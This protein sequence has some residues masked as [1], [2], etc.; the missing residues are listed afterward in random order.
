M[1]TA[2]TPPP[3]AGPVPQPPRRRWLA[4]AV[5]LVLLAAGGG[6]AYHYGVP[7]LPRDVPPPAPPEP[8][9]PAEAVRVRPDHV[10]AV[11]PDTP[12]AR[13]LQVDAVSRETTAAPL[14]TVTGSV[15]ARL[16]P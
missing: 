12:L 13:K 15:T 14:L 4:G 7:L 9:A 11:T 5:V 1:A 6:A 3:A 10:I 2:A 8:S 16:G